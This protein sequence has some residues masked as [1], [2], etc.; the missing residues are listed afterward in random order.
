VAKLIARSPVRWT[1]LGGQIRGLW[2]VWRAWPVSPWLPA[3]PA[4]C[5][6][7]YGLSLA[8]MDTLHALVG[9]V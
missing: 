7:S 1:G 6:A 2:R 5:G 3:S 8:G 4:R 9:G